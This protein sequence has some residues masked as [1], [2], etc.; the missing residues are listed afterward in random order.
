MSCLN[1]GPA[2]HDQESLRSKRSLGYLVATISEDDKYGD[3]AT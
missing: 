3:D 2:S 1:G